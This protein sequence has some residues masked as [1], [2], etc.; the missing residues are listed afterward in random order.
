MVGCDH[1]EVGGL[2]ARHWD[3]PDVLTSAIERHHEHASIPIDT[4]GDAIVFANYVAKT[5]GTSLGAEGMNARIHAG[6]CERLGVHHDS[7]D[8]I[9]LQTWAW[10]TDLRRTVAA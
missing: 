4:L 8:R 6:V 10:L 3:L 2:L 1:A 7:F 9:C 5:V